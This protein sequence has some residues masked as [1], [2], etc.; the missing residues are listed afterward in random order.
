MKHFLT[1]IGFYG[2]LLVSGI[3]LV[4]WWLTD[5]QKAS[6][7][8]AVILVWNRLD[9]VNRKLQSYDIRNGRIA[10]ILV[11]FAIILCLLSAFSGD[12]S[13]IEGVTLSAGK[14]TATVASLGLAVGFH[15][16]YWNY[17]WPWLK[18]KMGERFPLLSFLLFFCIVATPAA[19]YENG[20]TL[21]GWQRYPVMEE[22]LIRFLLWTEAFYIAV[23]SFSFVA[24]M[25]LLIAAGIMAVPKAIVRLAEIL[26][27][28]IAESPKGPLLAISGLVAAIAGL[29]KAFT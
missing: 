13:P 8:S 4:D 15:G 29:V 24:I 27:R 26:C 18:I 11:G 9:D 19:I 22:T 16:I 23:S 5:S 12:N 2:G 17:V 1:A 3:S 10:I 7:A 6:L 25:L 21:V 20:I 28:R 14:A